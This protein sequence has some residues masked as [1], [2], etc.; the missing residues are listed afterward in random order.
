MAI[1]ITCA[2]EALLFT[3][4]PVLFNPC[5]S[6]GRIRLVSLDRNCLVLIAAW[7]GVLAGAEAG[8][9]AQSGAQHGRG[10]AV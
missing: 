5:S 2:H 4:L 1:W 6:S 10:A 9:S 7:Q 8:G 3:A